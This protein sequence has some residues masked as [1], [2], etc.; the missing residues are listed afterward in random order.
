VRP[1]RSSQYFV[2]NAFN[3]K[4]QSTRL[5]FCIMKWCFFAWAFV[6][7]FLEALR[8]HWST[9][10]DF[11]K[12]ETKEK[13]P[14]TVPAQRRQTVMILKQCPWS[15]TCSK[16]RDHRCS[17]CPCHKHL[18]LQ[19]V[20]WITSNSLYSQISNW[21]HCNEV[22]RQHFFIRACILILPAVLF[23]FLLPKLTNEQATSAISIK[24]KVDL[25]FVQR[26][27]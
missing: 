17:S 22:W 26:W 21:R 10:E 2:I 25:S 3:L 16:R 6:P 11:L 7:N 9:E 15:R 14:N 1:L 27:L 19:A 23:L 18:L 20:S 24:L 5:L 8:G 4:S 12:W 13:P